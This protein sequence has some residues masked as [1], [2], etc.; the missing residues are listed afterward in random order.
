MTLEV[1]R[2]D[3]PAAAPAAQPL[4]R[5]H[6]AHWLFG[7]M[8]WR[9]AGVH[10][11]AAATLPWHAGDAA[12]WHELWALQSAVAERLQQQQR[13]WLDGCTALLQDYAQLGQANTVA[14]V[15][16]QEFDV[17]ARFNA[18]VKD[19]L[20]DVIELVENAQV[21]WGYWLSRKQAAAGD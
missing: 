15:V 5:A 10:A 2:G 11:A 6:K 16:D 14:K 7:Q 8:G 18:L 3:A 1:S 21:N 20:T 19:Q 13:A 17:A 12:T 4:L 9:A